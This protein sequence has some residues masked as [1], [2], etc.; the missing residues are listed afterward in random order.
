MTPIALGWL[1]AL[2]LFFGTAIEVVAIYFYGM[3]QLFSSEPDVFGGVLLLLPGP[4]IFGIGLGILIA[5]T[6]PKKGR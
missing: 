1:A 6:D 5:L 4:V 2:C 3:G